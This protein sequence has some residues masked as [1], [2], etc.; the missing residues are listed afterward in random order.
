MFLKMCGSKPWGAAP[1]LIIGSKQSDIGEATEGLVLEEPKKISMSPH[2]EKLISNRIY[3]FRVH[4]LKKPKENIYNHPLIH[5][6][7]E[8][9]WWNNL[10]YDEQSEWIRPYFTHHQNSKSLDSS[11]DDHLSRIPLLTQQ[12]TNLT[13]TWYIVLWCAPIDRVCLQLLWKRPMLEVTR[14]TYQCPKKK[15]SCREESKVE[16]KTCDLHS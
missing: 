10:K 2:G 8:K 7:N 16:E 4:C 3:V 14:L 1:L 13:S 11:R 15:G 6:S 5:D 9:L 12:T